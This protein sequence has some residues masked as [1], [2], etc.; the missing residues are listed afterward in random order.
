ML[1]A[2]SITDTRRKLLPL[3]ERVEGESYHFMITK[4]GKPAAVVISYEEYSQMVETLQ[5]IKDRGLVHE[6]M[7]GSAE[8]ERGNM[9]KLTDSENGS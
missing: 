3:I 5:L 1:E 4:H 7:Q 8:A 6:I 9:I 2:F